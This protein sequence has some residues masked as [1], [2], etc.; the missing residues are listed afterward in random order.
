VGLVG[1]PATRGHLCCGS[2]TGV[3]ICACVCVL[4]HWLSSTKWDQQLYFE[5]CFEMAPPAIQ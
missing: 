4:L 3:Q 2:T 5:K 1:H